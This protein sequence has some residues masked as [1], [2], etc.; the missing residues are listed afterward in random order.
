[1]RMKTRRIA[2]VFAAS[3]LLTVGLALPGAAS[4]KNFETCTFEKG[5]TTCTTVKGSHA[6]ESEHQGSPDS[7][8]TSKNPDRPCK[9]TGSEQTNTC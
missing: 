8:G 4:A 7:S 5:T 6:T 3:A 1:M 2:A 9:F